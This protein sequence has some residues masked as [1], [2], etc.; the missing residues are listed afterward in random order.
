M[1]TLD[2]PAE[3]LRLAQAGDAEHIGKLLESIGIT[4]TCWLAWRSDGT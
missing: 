2:S 1:I 3:L 4:S